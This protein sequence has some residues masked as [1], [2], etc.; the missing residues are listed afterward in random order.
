MGIGEGLWLERK[1]KVEDRER[2]VGGGWCKSGL[3]GLI[4]GPTDDCCCQ[5]SD[6]HALV[7]RTRTGQNDI[8]GICCRNAEFG[9][10]ETRGSGFG[11]GLI[12]EY[13][14]TWGQIEQ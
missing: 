12:L 6:E 11:G 14:E 3:L 10:M 4:Q 2:V 7:R 1:R 8:G 13:W 9:G 5:R